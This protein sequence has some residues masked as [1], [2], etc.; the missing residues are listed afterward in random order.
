MPAPS[1][2][3]PNSTPKRA[4]T[5][6]DARRFTLQQAN[7]AL[8][9]VGRIVADI[10]KTNALAN[11]HRERMES[12]VASKDV[13]AV[14]KDLDAAIDRLSDLV[15]EL[16]EVGVE[17]KD[18]ETGLVDFIGHHHDRNGERDIY[19]CWKLGEDQITHW[20][21]LNAGFTGRKPISTLQ[22]S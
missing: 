4:T 16:N 8:P 19:L 7:K 9:L 1:S 6:K 10:V 20:H 5:G 12:A 13:A 21:E 3:T 2:S 18:Y 15:D 17:L 11:S 22:E 14:Q